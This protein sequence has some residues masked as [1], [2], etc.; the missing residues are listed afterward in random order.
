MQR[1][2]DASMKYLLLVCWDTERMNT[3]KEPDRSVETGDD[4]GFPWLNE[5]RA[6]GAWILGDQ[7]AP[8]RRGRSVRRRGGR[9]IVTDGPFVETKETVGGFD[10]I[11]ADSL[12]A[13]VE[14]ASRHPVAEFG[15]IEV[16]PMWGQR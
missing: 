13:A 3:Q 14:I 7:L 12:D 9:A 6:R 8:P 16:R 4:E 11:E 10:L 15:T 1:S 2:E 5:L